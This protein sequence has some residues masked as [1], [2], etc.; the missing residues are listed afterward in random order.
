VAEEDGVLSFVE[1]K[2]RARAL[3]GSAVTAVSLHQ[4]RRVAR[5]AALYL[6]RTGFDGDC[7]FDV[8]GLDWSPS[9]WRFE[10]LR[11]AFLADGSAP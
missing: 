7:R 1:I 8:L 11:G 4:R 9:G 2:A 3:H 6:Q 5:A 10:L